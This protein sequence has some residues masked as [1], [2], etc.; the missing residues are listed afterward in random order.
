[1]S[2]LEVRNDG[3]TTIFTINRP[4]KMNAINAEVANELQRRFEEFDRSEQAVAIITGSGDRA[5]SSGADVTDL[6]ELW[7]CIPTIGIVTE[8]PIICAINGWC[9]GGALVMA[10][11]ADLCVVTEGTRFSYPEGKVG[12]TGGMIATLAARIPHKLAM[13]IMLLGRPVSGRRAYEIGLANEVVEDGKHL[14]A[15]LAMA[16][17]L[18]SMA[19]LVLKTLKRFVVE[20]TLVQTPSEKLARHARDLGVVRASS[21]LKEG[22]AAF[23]EKRK[24][25]F[26][27]R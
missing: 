25:V 27:G 16:R 7:R 12:L 23:K 17:E 8:K 10:A 2:A 4:E 13:E 18:E 3:K 20:H 6:P 15:A 5:F 26:T 24:P 14:E 11:M 1:M 9:V 19:P 22:L 21:D